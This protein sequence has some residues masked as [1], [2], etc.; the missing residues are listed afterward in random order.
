MQTNSARAI[1]H[2]SRCIQ[3]RCRK[4]TRARARSTSNWDITHPLWKSWTRTHVLHTRPALYSTFRLEKRD[5]EE[6][7]KRKT[8]L[9]LARGSAETTALVSA[10]S[11]RRA[12]FLLPN[13]AKKLPSASEPRRVEPHRPSCGAQTSGRINLYALKINY[14]PPRW[15]ARYVWYTTCAARCHNQFFVRWCAVSLIDSPFGCQGFFRK[16][17]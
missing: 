7:K 12:H 3:A 10:T 15:N 11:E 9:R 17:G 5:W 8:R 2:M 6:K 13:R 14:R 4:G 16:D 1:K